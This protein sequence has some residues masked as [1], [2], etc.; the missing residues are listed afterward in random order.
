MAAKT[1]MFIQENH[2]SDI[3]DV[4]NK[5]ADFYGEQHGLRA[6]LSPI[7][8]R[9]ETLDKHLL[10]SENFTKHR[11]LAAKRDALYAE[12]KRLD[13]KGFLFKGQAKK[14]L[15]AAEAYDWKNLN[16]L[17]DYDDAE[18][19][20]RRVLQ[21]RFDPKAIPV[22]KWR[23]ERETLAQELGG[24]TTE[25]EVLKERIREVEFIRKYAEKVHWEIN[26]PQKKQT[27]NHAL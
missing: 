7:N 1:L 20:L 18:K 12:Y 5:V 19:Y 3:G 21:K 9:I 2:L 4:R 26:M 10:H 22:K 16:G 17:R 11:K 25:Y 27:H 23:Q 24:I 14:A 6:R 15:E 13:G 8:R